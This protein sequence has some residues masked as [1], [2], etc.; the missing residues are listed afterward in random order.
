MHPSCRELS[1]D[2]RNMDLKHPGLVDLI[3][4]KQN[5]KNFPSFI[6][7][8]VSRKKKGKKKKKHPGLVDLI[9]TKQNK[10]TFLHSYPCW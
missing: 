9:T 8:L 6:S 10:K 5:K 4:T 2:T 3:T 7:M 1:K